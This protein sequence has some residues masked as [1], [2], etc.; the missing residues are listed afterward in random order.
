MHLYTMYSYLQIAFALKCPRVVTI[1]VACEPQS[2]PVAVTY[3]FAP[4][5]FEMKHNYH[6]PIKINA[7]KCKLPIISQGSLWLGVTRSL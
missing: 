2:F 7:V 6:M 4:K 5:A 3:A 1:A